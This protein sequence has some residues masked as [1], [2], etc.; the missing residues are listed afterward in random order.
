METPDGTIRLTVHGRFS[1]LPDV[2]S[3]AVEIQLV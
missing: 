3:R 2:G 1:P